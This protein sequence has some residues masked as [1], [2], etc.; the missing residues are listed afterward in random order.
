M[1]HNTYWLIWPTLIIYKFP[2]AKD[3]C[4]IFA[5]DKKHALPPQESIWL[6]RN[7]QDLMCFY[8]IR[9]KYG[10]Y[11]PRWYTGLPSVHKSHSAIGHH[12]I[13]ISRAL[14]LLRTFVGLYSLE[15]WKET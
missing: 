8:V 10:I 5:P 11:L 9:A 12:T 1:D 14:S 13:G 7:G 15:D 6:T 2:F 3:T 4:T